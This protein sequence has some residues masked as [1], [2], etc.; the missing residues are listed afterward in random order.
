MKGR[1]GV[2]GEKKTNQIQ[3]RLLLHENNDLVVLHMVGGGRVRD[4]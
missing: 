3:V 4:I 2:T 1:E